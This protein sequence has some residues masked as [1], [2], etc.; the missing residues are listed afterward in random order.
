MRLVCIS[1]DGV[2]NQELNYANCLN[3]DAGDCCD[4]RSVVDHSDARQYNYNNMCHFL[5]SIVPLNMTNFGLMFYNSTPAKIPFDFS[6]EAHRPNATAFHTKTNLWGFVALEGTHKGI[7]Q[8]RL[9][10]NQRYEGL[11]QRARTHVPIIREDSNVN[12]WSAAT[13]AWPK[14]LSTAAFS[15]YHKFNTKLALDMIFPAMRYLKFTN[16]HDL[17]NVKMRAARLNVF[18]GSGVLESEELQKGY[19]YDDYSRYAWT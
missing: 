15:Q 3:Y 16:L 11:T 6:F 4:P 13:F 10:W 5:G 7:F 9:P 1:D 12:R 18:S 17:R 8:A 19:N 14:L 2:C